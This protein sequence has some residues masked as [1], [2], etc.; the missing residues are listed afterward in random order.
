MTWWALDVRT[1]P[2]SHDAVASWLVTRTGQAV[3]ERDDG[4]VVGFAPTEAAARTLEHELTGVFP[5]SSIS[6]RDVEPIDWSTRWRDGISARRLGRLTL[7]PSWLETPE[8]DIFVTLDPETAFGSGEHGSTRGALV[9]LDRFVQ[10]GDRVLD[11]GTGSG[12]LA[13]AA[14]KLGARQA[15][16][17]EI[18]DE[19]LP[20]AAANIERNHVTGAVTLLHGD[21]AQLA[22]LCAPV[23]LV[24][25][26][27]LRGPNTDLLPVIAKTL[28]PGGMAIFAG[29][30]SR[31]SSLFRPSL[32]TRGFVVRDELVDA[33]WWAVAA[34][35]Q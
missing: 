3:E 30:E 35:H 25:S 26:N 22:P 14:V 28:K 29:M 2:A 18:D 27:I 6:L 32:H 24:V 20:I 5:E 7:S 4:T 12:I 8:T 34:S 31:E 15:V 33:G 10:T 16:G 23:D 21:A 9:L 19:A 1:V 17:I 11:L 13:I